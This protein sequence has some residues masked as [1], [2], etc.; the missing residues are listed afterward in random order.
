MSDLPSPD[1][2]LPHRPPFLLVDELVSI[3]PGTS[4]AGIWRL[5]GEAGWNPPS[6]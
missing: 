4:A 2:L 3:E 6:G 5:T 1:Q